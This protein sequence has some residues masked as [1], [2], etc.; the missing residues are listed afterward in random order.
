[1]KYIAPLF[2]FVFFSFSAVA[3]KNWKDKTERADYIHRAIKLLTDV[4]VHDI[5]SPPV[6][7]RT[8]AY[9]SVA[10]YEAVAAGNSNYQTLAGQLNGLKVLPK[11]GKGK[12]YSYTIAA[13]QAILAVGKTMVVSEDKVNAFYITV[14]K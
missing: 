2:F 14:M 3:E 1:M 8:Y 5:Y 7:S 11:P 4:M 6:S 9:I 13:V 12:E 10:G